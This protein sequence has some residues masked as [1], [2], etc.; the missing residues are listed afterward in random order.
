MKGTRVVI[1]FLLEL[2]EHNNSIVAI[3]SGTVGVRVV[4]ESE[5][6][7]CLSEFDMSLSSFVRLGSEMNHNKL[8]VSNMSCELITG[9]L[10]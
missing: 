3:L 9:G 8:V 1:L 5:F 6:I 7:I 10:K 4:E 2:S